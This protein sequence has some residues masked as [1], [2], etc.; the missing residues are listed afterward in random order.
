MPATDNAF[1]VRYPP[2]A[3]GAISG[4]GPSHSP[5][6]A[7]DHVRLRLIPVNATAPPVSRRRWRL[8]AV[9]VA[10]V[11]VVAVAGAVGW[12]VTAWH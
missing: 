3:S 1:G 4:L 12:A 6:P 5:E 10:V 2:P 11:A 9:L 8:V 7:I